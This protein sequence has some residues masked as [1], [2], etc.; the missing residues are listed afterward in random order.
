MTAFQEV[1]R[2]KIERR[3]ADPA[4]QDAIDDRIRV[5]EPQLTHDEAVFLVRKYEIQPAEGGC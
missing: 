3:K 2:L 1:V 4:R 5:L